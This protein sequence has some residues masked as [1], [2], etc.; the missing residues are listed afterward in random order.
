[1]I[2]EFDVEDDQLKGTFAIAKK[3][4]SKSRTSFE[5]IIW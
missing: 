2:S 5:H 3:R 1:M 4:F